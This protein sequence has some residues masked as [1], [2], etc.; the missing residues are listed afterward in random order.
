MTKPTIMSQSQCLIVE[1]TCLMSIL[2]PR[3]LLGLKIQAR[4]F[5]DNT[6]SKNTIKSFSE[7]RAWS[8][9]LVDMLE[10]YVKITC[11]GD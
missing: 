4:Y 5:A 6:T 2:N 11:H 9:G 3:S 10:I 8:A 7:T 1:K